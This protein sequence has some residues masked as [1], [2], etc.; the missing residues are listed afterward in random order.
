MSPLK[1]RKSSVAEII[2]FHDILLIVF[3]SLSIA[4]QGSHKFI[5]ISDRVG[6]HHAAGRI[7]R[8]NFLRKLL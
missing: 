5:Q 2:S 8:E 7:S 4:N 6:S 3:H 1:T